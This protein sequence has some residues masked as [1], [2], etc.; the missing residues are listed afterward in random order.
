[1]I[2]DKMI[3]SE[4]SYVSFYERALSEI[5]P[6][7]SNPRT[8]AHEVGE[9]LLAFDFPMGHAVVNQNFLNLIRSNILV[10][11]I[12]CNSCLNIIA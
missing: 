9:Q 5:L 11:I 2:V 12:L 8:L 6:N 3:S 7:C 10:L 4:K 1:M